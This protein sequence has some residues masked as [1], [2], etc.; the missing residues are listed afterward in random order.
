MTN[1]TEQQSY[2]GVKCLY[3]CQPIPISPLIASIEAE[4]DDIEMTPLKHLKCQVFNLRC[5]ACG[6]EKPYK[7][8]E[9]PELEG[10][11]AILVPRA[12]PTSEYF[13]QLG[14]TARLGGGRGQIQ[15]GLLFPSAL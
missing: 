15:P 1:E 13:Y 2:R 11:P 3:C 10:A 5:V 7:I 14:N 8:G 6:K 9:I 12:E 4:T